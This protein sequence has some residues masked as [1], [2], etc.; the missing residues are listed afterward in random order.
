[1]LNRL[2]EGRRPIARYSAI[3]THR[4]QG[5]V[6][7]VAVAVGKQITHATVSAIP[8]QA[9]PARNEGLLVLRPL[10]ISEVHAARGQQYLCSLVCS[11]GSSAAQCADRG[12]HCL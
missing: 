5:M 6:Q 1:M 9:L 3:Q 7:D 10:A 4:D 11:C 2:S 8:A 12:S